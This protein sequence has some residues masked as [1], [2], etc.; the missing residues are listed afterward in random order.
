MFANFHK[1]KVLQDVEDRVQDEVGYIDTIRSQLKQMLHSNSLSEREVRYSELIYDESCEILVKTIEAHSN[2]PMIQDFQAQVRR[3]YN[4]RINSAVHDTMLDQ[5]GSSWAAHSEVVGNVLEHAA[6]NKDLLRPFY[7]KALPKQLRKNIWRA[8][9]TYPEAEEEYIKLCRE[10]K[11]KTLSLNEV[12]ITKKS[13]ELMTEHCKGLAFNA[14]I[15]NAMKVVLSY[16]EKMMQRRLP[17]YMY[18]VLLPVFNVLE[19][20]A[21]SLPKLVGMGLKMAEIQT[22]VWAGNRDVGIIDVFLQCS[23][24]VTAAI[25]S[26]IRELLDLSFEET[27]LKLENFIRLFVSRLGVGVLSLETASV[28]FDQ[29]LMINTVNKLYYILSL[30]LSVIWTKLASV[31]HWDDF[32]SVF[33]REMKKITPVQL[34]SVL[35]DLPQAEDLESRVKVPIDLKG[36]DYLDYVLQ[37]QQMDEE[38]KINKVHE[39]GELL[40]IKRILAEDPAFGVHQQKMLRG[41]LMEKALNRTKDGRPG[42]KR[43]T[44]INLNLT[45]FSGGSKDRTKLSNDL[46]RFNN[47]KDSRELVNLSGSKVMRIEDNSF[48]SRSPMKVATNI[49]RNSDLSD[50]FSPLNKSL[51][52]NQLSFPKQS[53]FKEGTGDRSIGLN[54]SNFEESSPMNRSTSIIKAPTVK[55]FSGSQERM[56]SIVNDSKRGGIGSPERRESF[57]VRKDNKE[58]SES[59]D[60]S[61]EVGNREGGNE[62]KDEE[63]LNEEEIPDIS[64]LEGGLLAVPNIEMLK[65]GLLDG[66][67]D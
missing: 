5:A 17:D 63:I 54:R 16:I 53:I 3:I 57:S 49:S 21:D 4:Y 55:D 38:A 65:P 10:A 40:S 48:K 51:T 52:K 11:W 66:F 56:Q 28:V 30:C 34:E 39:L 41:T 44:L 47:S 1:L 25:E 23:S 22:T 33:F 14:K 24:R 26:K 18:Y 62:E 20:L 19:E 67:E 42:R 2:L 61:R 46:S 35:E 64:Y 6:Y 32:V 7:N 13:V 37:A 36:Q 27:R 43:Q 45:R 59:V 12:E 50:D 29:V 60:R 8:L 58:V 15:V 31:G 9:L